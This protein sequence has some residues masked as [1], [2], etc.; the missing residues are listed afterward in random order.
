MSVEVRELEEKLRRVSSTHD[1]LLIERSNLER[2]LAQMNIQAEQSETTH[3]EGECE[4]CIDG[5]DLAAGLCKWRLRSITEERL[6]LDFIGQTSET[7]VN[8][9]F[10]TSKTPI[11]YSVNLERSLFPNKWRFARKFSATVSS[12][13][14]SRMKLLQESHGRSSLESFSS[15][16]ELVR[17]V[18]LELVRA[19][20]VAMEIRTLEQRHDVSIEFA[21]T[22]KFRLTT[23]FLNEK[24]QQSVA[25]TFL[26]SCQYPTSPPSVT[27]ETFDEDFDLLPLERLIKHVKPGSGGI[28][29][30]L[31]NVKAFLATCKKKE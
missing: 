6:S 3:S 13:L 4:D 25:I 29:R 21:N 18:A 24:D 5:F 19:D 9:S 17:S 26:I 30:M 14:K 31:D 16:P 8:L 28:L 10:D 2:I 22:G 12:F 27:F 7:C 1:V 15:M 11:L 20:V 23:S